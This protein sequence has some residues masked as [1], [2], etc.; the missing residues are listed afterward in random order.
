MYRVCVYACGKYDFKRHM[1]EISG[2]QIV[3]NMGGDSGKDMF[4]DPYIAFS[5]QSKSGASS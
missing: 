5:R 4:D 3:A 1:A 2:C